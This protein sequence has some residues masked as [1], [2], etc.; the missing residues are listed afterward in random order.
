MQARHR[1]LPA[2]LF[3]SFAM[4]LCA[5]VPAHALSAAAMLD[6]GRTIGVRRCSRASTT[7]M[8][9]AGWLRG[10]VHQRCCRRADSVFADSFGD[11]G[12][13]LAVNN[14]SAVFFDSC[15]FTNLVSEDEGLVWIVDNSNARVL[16][17]DPV[18]EGT[19]S[20]ELSMSSED[21]GTF[22]TDA[23]LRVFKSTG[24]TTFKPDSIGSGT[25]D[26]FPSPTDP[27]YTVLRQARFACD[28]RLHIVKHTD[29]LSHILT[30]LPP[31][32][33][34]VCSH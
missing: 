9:G 4:L 12:Q 33:R 25:Y 18:F 34:L 1:S 8:Y 29:P 26:E 21:S 7:A 6:K 5:A 20:F 30:L 13:A 31:P 10:Q 19:D 28:T 11:K 3:V 14:Q 23:R 2:L 32:L 16:L 22:Y 27:Q 15:I 17:V 24:G